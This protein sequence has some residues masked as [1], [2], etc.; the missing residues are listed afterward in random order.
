MSNYIKLSTLEY[1]A[2]EGDI[3]LEYPDIAEHLTGDAFPFPDTFSRVFDT[4]P[5][6]IDPAIELFYEL[7]PVLQADGKYYQ[8]WAIREL[9]N[10]EKDLHA[11]FANSRK[12]IGVERI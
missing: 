5:P 1:P 12:K 2:H 9:T 8:S 3:R 6:T 7:A 11:F 4:P 10:E